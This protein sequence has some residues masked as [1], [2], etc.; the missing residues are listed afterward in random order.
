MHPASIA[1]LRVASSSFAV[2]KITGH[3]DPDDARRRCNSIP[4][5]PPR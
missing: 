4:E 2:M 5:I 3:F 1:W